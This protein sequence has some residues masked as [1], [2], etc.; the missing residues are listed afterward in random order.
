MIGAMYAGI[1]GLQSHQVKMDVVGNN[2]ANVNTAGYKKSTV[3]FAEALSQTK[4]SAKAPQDGLGGTNPIQIGLGT[5]VSSI[6]TNFTQGTQQS[7]GRKTDL[8]IDGEG[9]FML[10]DGN[11]S[12]YTRAGNFDLD[13]NGTL[14]A[15]NGMKVQGWQATKNTD[16]TTEISP[17]SPISELNIKLG[18]ILPGKAT[19]S[20][21]YRGNLPQSSGIEPLKMMVDD[22]TGT[23]VQVEVNI[24]FS[25]NMAEDTWTWKASGANIAEGRGTFK[26][27]RG[28]IVNAME[29]EPI[30]ANNGNH[31]LKSPLSGGIVFTDS[32]YANNKGTAK[33]SSH[34]IIT[35]GDVYDSLGA[36]HTMSMEYSKIDV[37][38]WGWEAN[39]TKGLQMENSKG[40]V[41]FDATGQSAGNF[42]FAEIDPNTGLFA[43]L[44]DVEGKPLLDDNGTP[45]NS[46]PTPKKLGFDAGIDTSDP[47]V[48]IPS[49]SIDNNG[50]I[51]YTGD[52]SGITDPNFPIPEVGAIMN[53]EYKGFI[54]FDPA[55]PGG[56]LPPD[57]GANPVKIVPGFGNITQFASENTVAFEAQDGYP[58]GELE[59]FRIN[60][61][62]DVMGY[63]S[64]G[65]KQVVGRI[66]I[67]KFYN[68]NGLE[69]VGGSL[70][71]R[72]PN[73]GEAL[74]MQPGT[75]G[76]GTIIS[77]SLEMSN[78]DL[79]EEFTDMIIAQ[80]GFQANSKTITTADEM[81]QELIN[82][83]R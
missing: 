58:M 64:N 14:V 74:I 16:G 76:I 41:I 29:I 43:T 38:I 27:D 4:Q 80:R 56:A 62:G 66:A 54:M 17:G 9:F 35:S 39:H 79:S 72:T 75:G 60:D 42:L 67:T 2:I 70:F 8:R 77:D 24:E 34:Q 46:Y 78:V 20:V 51:R 81:L 31:I 73:S 59:T 61:N 25:Y 69:K 30:R 53:A 11:K 21:D 50:I 71:T 82:L 6:S 10:N 18:E 13:G 47:T 45:V 65:Y 36:K 44:K 32:T 23:G 83:K 7:T 12:Y 68:P 5:R 3:T 26:L 57:E 33:Y 52:P 1:S 22:G 49:Y 37:N 15:S 40:F 63:Y 28:E 48:Y 55:N 19:K